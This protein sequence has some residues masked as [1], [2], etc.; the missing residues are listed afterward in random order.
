MKQISWLVSFFFLPSFHSKHSNNP[1]L[2]FKGWNLDDVVSRF[3]F[4]GGMVG[5]LAMEYSS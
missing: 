3:E 5:C 4:G 2:L 1:A